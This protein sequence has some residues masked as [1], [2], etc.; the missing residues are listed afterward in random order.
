MGEFELKLIDCSH[1]VLEG[2][3]YPIR[4]YQFIVAR[5][6][7]SNLIVAIDCWY[8]DISQSAF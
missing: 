4:L 2:S 7:L 1:W 8:A 5:Q 6:P 3:H